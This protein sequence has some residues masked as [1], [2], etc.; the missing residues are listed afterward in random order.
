MSRLLF[1]DNLTWLRDATIF[2]DASVDLVYL[3][4][5]FNSNADCRAEG[6]FQPPGDSRL[7]EVV[8]RHLH[9]HAVA[10]GEAHPAFAHLAAN[11]GQHDMFVVQFDAKHRAGQHGYDSTFDFYVLFTHGWQ[12]RN[13]DEPKNKKAKSSSRRTA[14]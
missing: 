5:P 2:P 6:L 14:T 12:T 10:N 4:P 7:V 8:G 3:A 9:F 11:G 13:W 1:G